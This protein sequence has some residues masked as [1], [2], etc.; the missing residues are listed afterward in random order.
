MIAA[1]KSKVFW[2]GVVVWLCFWPFAILIPKDYLFDIVNAFSVCVGIGVIIAYMPGIK[3]AL[4]ARKMTAGQFL[5]LG[6]ACT[7]L[8]TVGRHLYNW[9]WRYLGKPEA[10]IDHPMVAFLVVMLVSGGFLHLSASHAIDEEFPETSWRQLGIVTAFSLAVASF[11]ILYFE[12]LRP[13]PPSQPSSHILEA[14]PKDE[15]EVRIP[16]ASPPV[17]P[18]RPFMP[19]VP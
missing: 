19:G 10:M 6:I 9:I 8:A 11:F 5:I 4:E 12:P 3:A 16:P 13:S 18:S 17:S 1:A 7:W 2:T 14:I 15:R